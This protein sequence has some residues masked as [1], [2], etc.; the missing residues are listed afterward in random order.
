MLV[1]C[2]HNGREH[3]LKLLV[4]VEAAAAVSPERGA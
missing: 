1:C 2:F 4:V 3:A